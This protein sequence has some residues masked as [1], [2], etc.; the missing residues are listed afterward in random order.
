MATARNQ[1]ITSL[2]LRYGA[3]PRIESDSG[4]S[5]LFLAKLYSH[6]GVVEALTEYGVPPLGPEEREKLQR[7]LNENL[8]AKW[9][10]SIYDLDLEMLTAIDG[11]ANAE[12]AAQQARAAYR[13]AAAAFL[14]Q[15]KE[16]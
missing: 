12:E 13:K 10:S 6:T 15:T 7:K 2:L 1:Q 9:K 3:D 11:G 14:P 8:L 5:P 16:L 4:D